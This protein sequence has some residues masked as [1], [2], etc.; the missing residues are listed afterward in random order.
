MQMVHSSNLKNIHS[1]YP[2]PYFKTQASRGCRWLASLLFSRKFV[3]FMCKI[4]KKVVKICP[5]T[6]FFSEELRLA[7][8]LFKVSGPAPALGARSGACTLLYLEIRCF[9]SFDLKSYFN[10][11]LSPLKISQRDAYYH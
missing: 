8:L 11:F 1:C 3:I 6:P 7:S 4:D 9:R 10:Q 2:L 5:S